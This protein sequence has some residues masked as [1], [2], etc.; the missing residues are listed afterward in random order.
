M[1]ETN[2]HVMES[3]VRGLLNAIGVRGFIGGGFA[4]H[5][6]LPNFTDHLMPLPGDIDIFHVNKDDDLTLDIEGLGYR[7]TK[8]LV[9]ATEFRRNEGEL[10]VQL[11]KPHANDTIK[12][13]GSIEEVLSNFDFTVNMCALQ[14]L[15]GGGS[16]N[17]YPLYRGTFGDTTVQDNIDKQLVLNHINCPIAMLLRTCKYIGKGYKTTMMNLAKIVVA[18]E[19][20]PDEYRYKIMEYV[21]NV[22]DMVPDDFTAFYN[23]ILID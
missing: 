20:M 5:A 12:M 14:R 4:R 9:H 13:W 2:V 3:Q 22:D 23:M 8:K 11:I 1:I 15:S 16:L 17:G 10:T 21:E 7:V 19:E 18:F 6:I